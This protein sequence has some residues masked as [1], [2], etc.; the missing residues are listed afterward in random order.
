MNKSFF[1][2]N[3]FIIGIDIGNL[4]SSISYFN[5]NQ[6]I[7]DIVDASGGYSKASI[8]TLVSYNTETKEFVFG[9]HAILNKST[10]NDFL[11]ENIFENLPKNTEYN[12]NDEKITDIYILSKY[13]LF[14]IDNI[15]SINPNFNIKGIVLA[16]SSYFNEDTIKNIKKAFELAGLKDKLIKI[17][18]YRECILNIYFYENKIQNIE[19]KKIMLLDYA[20]RQVRVSF[21]KALK[22]N[23]ITCDKTFFKEDIAQNRIYNIIKT[24]II[25]K[26]KEFTK[27]DTITQEE[28]NQLDIFTYQQFDFI[29][30]K[31]NMSD[32]KLYYNFHYPPFQ[33]TIHKEEIAEITS[34]FKK[35]IDLFFNNIFKEIDFDEKDYENIILTGGTIELEFISNILKQK[36]LLSKSFKGRAK[37]L[38]SDGACL[39]ACQ[40]MNILKESDIKIEDLNLVKNDI[41]IFIDDFGKETFLP[42][43]TK[44]SFIWDKPKKQ[45]FNL[46]NLS[47]N[48]KLD[49]CIYKKENEKYTIIKE[50]SIDFPFFDRDI[51]T[52]RLSLEIK[53]NKI[54]EII[55]KIEDFGFGE[56]FPKTDF[57]KEIFININ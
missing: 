2:E 55:L 48:K 11:F 3:D 46:A 16:I 45:V 24:L 28:A 49:F 51:K 41:G 22:N 19:N 54:N 30:Q 31:G 36:F 35:E 32:V 1:N 17:V 5:F 8:P 26:F 7:F 21:Y 56:I 40:H 44:N 6:N 53:F 57:E 43:I 12:I 52:I 23:L 13:I 25:K 33:A 18:D 39:I 10:G 38:V 50:I 14:L 29:F 42:F 27:K 4:T 20:N 9:E 47:Y 15:K 37:R 34:F